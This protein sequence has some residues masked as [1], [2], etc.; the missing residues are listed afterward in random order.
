[1]TYHLTLPDAG[2]LAL[3]PAHVYADIATAHPTEL[4][5]RL[6]EHREVG[7]TDRVAFGIRRHHADAPHAVALLRPRDQRPRR[8]R[9]ATKEREERAA[10]RGGAHSIT[11]SARRSTMSGTC[12]PIALAVFM[13][14]TVS[15]LVGACTG[16]SARFSPLRI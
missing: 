6:I 15:N 13:L 2:A 11:S 12:R 9:G 3:P 14:S 5:E 1:D 8:R 10:V 4:A 7:P 16:R